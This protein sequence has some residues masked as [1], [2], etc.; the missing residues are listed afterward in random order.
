M[1]VVLRI[2]LAPTGDILG[3]VE[4]VRSSG[5]FAFDRAAE[6]AV[7]KVGRFR[8]L[9]GMPPRMFERNFRSL[10]LTFRPEDLLN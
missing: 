3:N 6:Q 7:L 2:R 10:L 1:V 5:D 9:Q 4:I 8:E